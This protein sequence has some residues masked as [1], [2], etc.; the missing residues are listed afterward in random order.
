VY[1][2]LGTFGALLRA[3]KTSPPGM[4]LRLSAGSFAFLLA[5]YVL[6]RTLVVATHM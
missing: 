1:M 3:F 2:Y 5:I 6:L 4:Y